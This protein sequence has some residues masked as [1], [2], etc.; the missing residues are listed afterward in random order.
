MK[1][2]L[3]GKSNKGKSRVNAFGNIWVVKETF[4]GFMFGQDGKWFLVFPEDKPDAD[5]RWVLSENDKDF[6][7]TPS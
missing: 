3:K 5:L 1:L 7:V 2:I 4:N 6:V